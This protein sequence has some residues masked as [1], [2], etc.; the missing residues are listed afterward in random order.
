MYLFILESIGTAELFLVALVA[1]IVFGPRKLPEMMRKAGKIM[2]EFRKTTGEFKDSWEKEVAG[3]FE[4]EKKLLTEDFN[5]EERKIG[6]LSNGNENAL[7]PEIKD[8]DQ[9]ELEKKFSKKQ[10]QSLKQENEEVKEKPEEREIQI[11]EKNTN[12]KTSW[13]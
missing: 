7:T 6:N 11:A 12:D 5:E 2:A 1:L 13:L 9:S 4:E 8:L 10:I 3:S